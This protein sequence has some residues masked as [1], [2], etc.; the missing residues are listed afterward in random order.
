MEPESEDIGV[1]IKK[2]K[3]ISDDSMYFVSNNVD[4]LDEV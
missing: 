1:K 3:K 4:N 2:M